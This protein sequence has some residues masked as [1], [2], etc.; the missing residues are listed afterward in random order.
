MNIRAP[1]RRRKST[2]IKQLPWRQIVNPFNPLQIISEDEVEAVHE[3]A[4][5]LLSEVGVRCPVPEAQALTQKAGARIDTDNHRVR[6]G[7]DIVEAALATVPSELTL[8]PRNPAHAVRLGGRHMATATILGPPNSTNLLRGRRSG[9]MADL[10]ELLQLTQ[11]FN[12]VQMNGWVVE[13]LDIEVRYRHLEAAL[14]M[15]TITDKVP[16]IFSQSRQRIEDV[17]SL[18][19]M[20]RGESLEDFG[21]RPGV[22]SVINSN[23]PLQFD[24]PMTIGVME[25]ARHGQPTLLTPFVIAGASTPN[26]LASALAL[27]T[28]EILFGV[29]LSQLVRPGAPVFYGLAALNVDMKTGS[30]AYGWAD[31][32]RCSIAGAQM[33]RRY[34]LPIRS[35]GFSSP[36]APDFLAGSETA[37]S[38]YTAMAAGTHFLLHAVGWLEGGLCTS[39]EKFVLDCEI[40]QTLMHMMSPAKID[41]DELALDE[42]AEVGPG[43][44]FF[45]TPRT[46]ATYENAFYQPLTAVTQNHGAWLEAGSKSAAERALPIWQEALRTYE[47]PAL[48]P[49]R[50]EAMRAFVAKR[51]EEGGAP[52]D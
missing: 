3:A 33:A 41:A 49:S 14:A 38:S 21:K 7:R 26:T 44:H 18:C 20:A 30:P 39:Y 32:H 50:A 48:D 8:T 37:T 36:N 9:S 1:T 27:N 23:T 5:H 43:G 47:Q 2:D 24:V 22:Y 29:V 31:M 12:A 28:A 42:I 16:Y 40:I 4:L 25:M 52:L 19:A 11:Y 35:S 13:P 17:L 45:G 10:S 34:N 51:K 46:I 15:L 6:L